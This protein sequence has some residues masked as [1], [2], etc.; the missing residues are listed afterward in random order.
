MNKYHG[1]SL[2]AAAAHENG[3]G[4]GAAGHA[5]HAAAAAHDGFSDFSHFVD[6]HGHHHAAAAAA[7]AGVHAHHGHHP[8][9]ARSPYSV[10]ASVP[11]PPTSMPPAHISRPLTVLRPNGKKTPSPPPPNCM[12][13]PEQ[14]GFDFS[15]SS[16]HRAT[17]L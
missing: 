10:Y 2:A 3:H 16:A 1:L 13:T 7:A 14:I 6:V 12:L 9:P 15:P 5:A 4:G 17:D 8:G 11:P